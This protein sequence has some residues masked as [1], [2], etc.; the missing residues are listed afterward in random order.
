M[1]ICFISLCSEFGSFWRQLHNAYRLYGHM[2]FSSF[3]IVI[4]FFDRHVYFVTIVLLG[5]LIYSLKRLR[6]VLGPV[7]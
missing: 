1:D 6:Y 5:R 3:V 4:I 7:N 2:T